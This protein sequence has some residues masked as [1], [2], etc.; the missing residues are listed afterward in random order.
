M[1]ATESKEVPK[2]PLQ[3]ILAAVPRKI[4]TPL[5][6][7]FIIFLAAISLFASI[8]EGISNHETTAFDDS[9]LLAIHMTSSTAL[10][11]LVSLLTEFGGLI[12]VVVLTAGAMALFAMRRKWRRAAMLGVTVAGAS[13][14]NLLLKVIFAR[15]RPDLWDHIVTELSYSFPSGHAMASMALAAGLVVATWNTQYRRA[16]L[17]GGTGYVLIIAFTRLYLGVH[18]PTDIIAGWCVS[19]AWALAVKALF[20]YRLRTKVP[21][22]NE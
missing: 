20:T 12:G 2:R 16:A 4:W 1:K 14:L 6:I 10:D 17:I 9:I 13:A 15:S 22:I 19:I 5:G 18:Y 11:V 7:A 3:Q 8:A 21:G